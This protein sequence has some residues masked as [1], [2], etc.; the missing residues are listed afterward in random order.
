M[1]RPRIRIGISGWRYEP[2]RGVFYPDDL[3]QRLELRYASSI[4]PTI[5]INGSFYS[6]Q[7]PTSWRQWYA[8]TPDDFLFAVKGPR[9]I[10]HMLRL[11]DVEVPLANFLASGVLALREK[12]GPILWQFPPN[13]KFDPARFADFITLLPT[14]TAEALKLA[15]RRNT[16][17]MRGR[18]V[19]AVDAVR[20]LRHAMEI[21]NDSFLDERFI[22]LLREHNVALVIAETA[23]LWPMLRDVTADFM[24]LRLHGDQEI[25]R[26]GYRAPAIAR[27]AQRIEQWNAG[28]EPVRLP[29]GAVRVTKPAPAAPAGREIFCYFDNTDVK[30]RA[31]RDAQSL[32]RCLGLPVG[33][34]TDAGL[35][36][37]A[38]PGRR[39]ARDVAGLLPP[40]ARVP[41][42]AARARARSSATDPGP[43]D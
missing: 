36:E 32:M 7:R 17:R 31:P 3:P 9:F 10:T 5:E 18:S 1:D 24:Y 21:R 4:F 13:L 25:Y 20:P 37:P 28:D 11:R 15:R 38:T 34:W 27:W 33:Q 22:R 35:R 40:A 30:L 41:R 42:A 19:L 6:L 29:E 16:S 14:T 2:W 8:E 26:S 39:H 23:R 43:R 12:L